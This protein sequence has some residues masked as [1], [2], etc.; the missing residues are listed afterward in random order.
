MISTASV[1]AIIPTYNRG[2][3]V[4]S[5]LE[6]IEQCDPKPTEIWIHIDAADGSLESLLR[7]RFPNVNTLVS[8]TR[9][10]CSGGRHQCLLACK[11][12][13]AVSFDDDSYPVDADFFGQVE[14]LFHAYPEV[15]VFGT[16]N[17]YRKE[18]A[19]TRTDQ[20]MRS[21][22]FVGCGFAIRV[23]AYRQIRGFLSRPL[24][25]G[26]EE[27][28][29]SLQLLAAGWKIY[30]A[31]N[32]RV[33]HDTDLEHRESPEI[34]SAVI[35]NVALCAF[36]HYPVSGFA[37]GVGQVANIVAWHIRRGKIRGICS[38]IFRI[39]IDCYRNRQYRQPI[40]RGQL[41]HFLH[42]LRNSA[43]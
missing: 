14:R 34:V 4:T 29:V 8:S 6:K 12:P 32:L 37:W 27:S 43:V 3:A 1:A 25:Y 20:L 10:G 28:D 18:P 31:G 9:L 33:F 16:S 40:T 30:Q 24:G 15:A 11:A 38:G 17:W 39:P 22:S 41:R 5:V 19:R 21:A 42:C 2:V 7:E 13:I 26:I 23:A 36:L 35:T